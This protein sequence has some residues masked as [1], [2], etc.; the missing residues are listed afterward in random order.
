MERSSTW[1]LA[2]DSSISPKSA[3]LFAREL[4]Q[5]RR[6]VALD[7]AG[8]HDQRRAFLGGVGV[9]DRL[10]DRLVGGGVG[11]LRGLLARRRRRVAERRLR[12]CAAA[13]RQRADT[14]RVRRNAFIKVR[15]LMPVLPGIRW[16]S[17]NASSSTS[18]RPCRA[19]GRGVAAVVAVELGHDLVDLLVHERQRHPRNVRARIRARARVDIG[20]D[21]AVRAGQREA[22][23]HR[24]RVDRGDDAGH[25][26][27]RDQA[28]QDE[29]RAEAPRGRQ[30]GVRVV[31]EIGVDLGLRDLPADLLGR[32]RQQPEAAQ[33]RR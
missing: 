1:K 32:E 27:R 11:L 2:A 29:A 25:R 23:A 19:G 10:V 17:R 28:A 18:A 9:H 30:R 3:M 20:N 33:P 7:L 24:D 15:L 31:L 16:V 8:Q 13:Q 21:P 12:R 22:Q 4:L 6:V 26:L 14:P 5:E